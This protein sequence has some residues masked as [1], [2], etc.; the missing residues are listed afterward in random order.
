MLDSGI[1]EHSSSP[2]ASPIVL[3]SKQDGST[4]FCVEYCRLNAITKLDEFSLP[5][6]DDSL[7][8]LAGMKHFTTLDL[9]TCYWQVGKEPEAKEKTVFMTHEGLYE[10]SVMPFG[11][12]NAPATFQCLMEIALRGLARHKCVVYL[13]DVMVIGQIFEDHL[14]DLREMLERLRQ[15]GLKLKPKKCHLVQSEV[16]Y[17]GYVVSESVDASKVKAV[18]DFLVP[19]NLKQLRS[20]LGLASYYWRFMPGFLQLQSCYLF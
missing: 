11:L 17:L 19:K 13:D 8:L 2:W 6:V 4:R 15:A 10:F 18:R 14:D 9:A 5:C 16:T 7:D 1:I 3:V 20:F 12:C